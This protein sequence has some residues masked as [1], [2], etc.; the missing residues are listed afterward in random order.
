MA[1]S[2][3]KEIKKCHNSKN[4]NQKDVQPKEKGKDFY[5]SEM[6]CLKKIRLFSSF[7]FFPLF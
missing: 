6:P 3:S 1:P 5:I 7:D 2:Q 4:K